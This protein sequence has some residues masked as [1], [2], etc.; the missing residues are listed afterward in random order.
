MVVKKILSEIPLDCFNKGK[1]NLAPSL[2][3]LI[4]QL[5]SAKVSAEDLARAAALTD[6]I[7]SVK[8][9][10]IAAVFSAYETYIAEN[11]LSDQGSALALLPEIVE[12][13]AEIAGADVFI[14][15]YSGFTVQIR[16]VISAI[17]SRAKSCT[18]ILTGGEN[19]FAFVNETADIFKALCAEKNISVAEKTVKSEYSVGGAIIKDGLFNPLYRG[20]KPAGKKPV[21]HFL[22]AKSVSAETER[23]AEVIK[24]KVISGECRF[25]DFTVIIPFGAE[26]KETARKSFNRLSVPY[27]IDE[28]RKPENFPVI[29]LIYAYCDL[30][31]RGLKI[32]TLSAFFKNPYVCA[33]K[34]FADGF[35][36]YLYKYDICYEKFKKPFIYPT[37]SGDAEELTK[38]EEFRA[39]IAGLISKFDVYGILDKLNVDGKTEELCAKLVSMGET[40][41][42]EV[43]RQAAEKAKGII[44]EMKFLLSADRVDPSEF[45]NVFKSGVSAMEIS[46]IPQYNDAVFVGNFKQAAI[47]RSEYLFVAGL[48]GAVPSFTEDVALLTD[49]D[50]DALGKVKVLLEPKINVVNHRL[51]EETALGLSAYKK[52]IYLSYPL[53]DYSGGQTTKSDILNFAEKFFDLLAFPPYD[54]YIT[55]KQGMRSFARDCS[56]FASL[57]INDFSVQSGFYK[58][59]DGA[60][61]RIIR[62]AN[63]E[64]KVRLEGRENA[65]IFGITSP[66]AIEDY[67][68]CPY[69]SFLI[70]TLKIKERDTGKV[71]ALSVGNLMHDIFKSFVSRIDEATDVVAA[72]RLFDAVSEETLSDVN[73]ARFSDAESSF[74]VKLALNECRKYCRKMSRWYS[75]SAFKPTK[76]GLE[77]K[78]GENV[79]KGE[80]Y[81]AVDLLGGKVKLSGKIDR[82]DEFGNYF[83][84]IDY[85]TGGSEVGDEK[86]FAGVKLQLYLYSLAVTDKTLAGAYYL[87]V[88]DEYKAEGVKEKPLSEGKTA[89]DAGLSY[90]GEE[91]FIP[92]TGKNKA[93]KTETLSAVQKYVKNLAEQAAEQLKNGVIIPSPYGGV[94]EYCEFAAMCGRKLKE[95]KVSGVDTE[96]IAESAAGAADKKV[97]DGG[98]E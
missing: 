46:V 37:A 20:E 69:R 11:G 59:T 3:E 28:K 25:R 87:R 12:N 56:R 65:L 97:T 90:S 36:N 30:F 24:R 77:V 18:A 42:A 98:K 95:R 78:F 45:K 91:E 7:L 79:K 2:F 83:R 47:A 32:P 72:D 26:Y 10:D 1:L 61:E 13:D 92:I 86:I 96:F 73:Y 27:F 67:Y 35:E 94:C 5:K 70:H 55:E 48:T 33:D 80:G 57:K 81:P 9:K 34:N 50:I 88:N 29:S 8:L 15:G 40:E 6:G 60:P 39:Y 49:G 21:A 89:D 75:V 17:L 31:I 54:G 51:R 14:L 38:F 71:N 64:L 68:T 82:V 52:G 58:A 84:I 76:S 23:I 19:K 16:K 93:V 74:G 41:D 22:A 85:K 53:S 4:S 44:S 66:T 43:N 62:Y 63:K